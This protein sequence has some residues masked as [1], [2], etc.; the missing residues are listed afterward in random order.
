MNLFLNKNIYTNIS[1]TRKIF[2]KMQKIEL[3]TNG[4]VLNE[5]R[6]LKIIWSLAYQLY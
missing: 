3:I 1:Q 4:D 5:K 2:T 6:I